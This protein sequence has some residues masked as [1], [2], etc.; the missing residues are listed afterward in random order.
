MDYKDWAEDRY[1]QTVPADCI[2]MGT[3]GRIPMETT[4][5]NPMESRDCIPMETKDCIPMETTN[6]IPAFLSD[7]KSEAV[8]HGI[9]ADLTD[10]TRAVQKRT[11]DYRSFRETQ[12]RTSAA[13]R[14]GSL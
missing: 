13:N 5:C 6:C 2:P 10:C 12:L 3:K 8:N 4:D 14:G 1:I 9:P 11:D 7:Y